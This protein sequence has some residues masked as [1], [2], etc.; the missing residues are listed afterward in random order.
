MIKQGK[1]KRQFKDTF[2]KAVIVDRCA[3]L[4]RLFQGPRE[5]VIQMVCEELKGGSPVINVRKIPPVSFLPLLCACVSLGCIPVAF[6][7]AEL[8]KCS[9]RQ[10]SYV[11]QLQQM[12][13]YS[14]CVNVVDTAMTKAKSGF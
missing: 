7:S 2:S 13:A 9:S 14:G 3:I 12:Q 11:K 6:R 10:Q 1:R 5:K 4:V 8:E